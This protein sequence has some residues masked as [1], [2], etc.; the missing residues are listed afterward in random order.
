MG[1][2]EPIHGACFVAREEGGKFIS[3]RADDIAELREPGRVLLTG[4][5]APRKL[6]GTEFGIYPYVDTLRIRCPRCYE[7]ELV[8]VASN[9]TSLEVAEGDLWPKAQAFIERHRDCEPVF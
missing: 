2:T 9:Y 5:T 1:R 3:L 6:N 7:N 4:G 8:I